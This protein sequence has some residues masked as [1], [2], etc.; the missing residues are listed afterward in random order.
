MQI[1]LHYSMTCNI[2]NN[3]TPGTPKNPTII[4]FKGLITMDTPNIPPTRLNRK[5]I[6]PS[7]KTIY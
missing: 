1:K 4:A 3:T 2:S 5:R 7:Y 6:T